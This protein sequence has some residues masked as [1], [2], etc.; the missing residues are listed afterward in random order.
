MNRSTKARKLA[1]LGHSLESLG[2]VLIKRELTKEELEGLA[3]T[4]SNVTEILTQIQE[5]GR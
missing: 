3:Q 5:E 2:F 4:L 1:S